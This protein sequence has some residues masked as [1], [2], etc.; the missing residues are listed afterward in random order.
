ML[1]FSTL[2]LL[3]AGYAIFNDSSDE[4][5]DEDMQLTPDEVAD[6]EMDPLPAP[7]S[8]IDVQ[9]TATDDVVSVEQAEV[10]GGEDI[11]PVPVPDGEVVPEVAL[12]ADAVSEEDTP[13]DVQSSTLRPDL[14]NDVDGVTLVGD[15]SDE[16]LTGSDLTDNVDGAGGDDRIELLGGEDLGLGGAG[17]DT[18]LGRGGTD[19]IDGGTGNDVLN[20]GNG[21]D[22]LY[23]EE[24]DDNLLGGRGDDL[25]STGSGTDLARGGVG[26]DYIFAIDPD[27][28]DDAPDTVLGGAGNDQIW[29]DDGDVLYGGEGVN[30]FEVTVGIAGN[31]PVVIK[32]LNLF[33]GDDAELRTDLVSFIDENGDLFTRQQLIDAETRAE[34]AANGEDA[35]IFVRGELA[36][37]IEGYTAEDLLADTNWLGNLSPHLTGRLD[38]NDLVEGD[39]LVAGS[40]DDLFGGPGNDTLRGGDG[41]DH[42]RGNEGD[43]ILDGTDGDDPTIAP[44]TLEGG[45]GND[46]LRGD[47]GDLIGGQNGTDL[48]EVIVPSSADDAPVSIYGYEAQT[49]SGDTE[50]LVLLDTD[51]IP[52]SAEDVAA[53]LVIY[54]SADGSEAILEYAGVQV[55]LMKG[56]DALVLQNQ[57][58]WIGNFDPAPDVGLG[59]ESAAT[60]DTKISMTLETAVGTGNVVDSDMFGT[61]AVYSVNTDGGVPLENYVRAVDALDVLNVRYPAGQSDPETPG[62]EGETWL[63][64]MEL[65]EDENGELMLRPEV[66]AALDAVIEAHENGNDVKLVLGVPTKIF[67]VEEYEA[68]YDNMVRFTE[69]VIEQYGETVSAFEVGNE[70]WIQGETAYGQK[71]DIAARAFAE[72]MRNAGLDEDDQPDIIVQMA[73]PNNGSEFHQS[74]D[75]RSFGERRDDANRQ[76]IAQLSEEARDAIDGVVE[77]YYYNKKLDV[78]EEGSDE[79]RYIDKDY[80]I[81]E[82][83]FDKE[84]DMHITE[85][86]VRTTN[87]EQNGMRAAGV[88]TEQFENMIEM[89]A[90]GAHSWPAVHNTNS[91]LAGTRSDM[92]ITDEQDRVLNSVRGAMFDVMSSELIGAELV[93]ASFSND[94][95]RIEVQTYQAP[96]K[97]IFQ[98]ASRAGEA[99]ELDLDVSTLV[100]N[101]GNITA[102]RI[103]YDQSADS[104][105]GIYRDKEG[106]LVEAENTVIDGQVY[107]FNEHDVRATI[108]DLDIDSNEFEVRLKP[109]EVLQV[110]YNLPAGEEPGAPP[111]QVIDGTDADDTI[112][113]EGGNDT[114]SGLGGSDSINGGDGIDEL[115]GGE[116]DDKLEGGRGDDYVR[117]NEGDDAVYG[118][119]GDDDMKGHD[120]NDSISGNEGRDTLSGSQGDDLLRGGDDQDILNGGQGAD[121]LAG[122]EGVDTLTGYSGADLFRFSEDH[123]AQGDVITDFEVGRDVIELSY[124][125]IQSVGDLRFEDVSQGVAIFVGDHGGMLLQGSLTAAQMNDP[126]N[127]IFLAA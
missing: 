117:G 76:I 60:E 125:D 5:N 53:N 65:E 84:L 10:A 96:G 99:I 89:G 111:N 69:L 90:D 22:F 16:T 97:V 4:S 56:M 32:D 74:V 40:D 118:F 127:F 70:Y 121:T 79:K 28:A 80:G 87:L 67:T 41:S 101:Y 107:Y 119:G 116:G 105:D 93:D 31:D 17:D 115:F 94:D 13:S 77:H 36:V 33:H 88:L 9:A 14:T 11:D 48:Y 122:G 62:G 126:R 47:G 100:P 57:D 1:F 75:D 37:I 46:T 86:N 98:V 2:A 51:G 123:M 25:I 30:R 81:W 64:I 27:G 6:E 63:N 71:A 19:V 54:Q 104:S 59:V 7:D 52:L 8:E 95:G 106:N 21:N 108:E 20:G 61:N 35:N 23:G 73:T 66:T 42:L 103:G 26:D 24:G 44:D 34:D 3:I 58:A 82:E 92:P 50:R 83:A 102:V 91:H 78:F 49:E 85:W 120:G 39:A 112:Q 124:D 12:T 109:Y 110:V 114:I 43:D 72:G 113:S 38:G 55:A 45:D 15:N 29:G 68:M 18:I